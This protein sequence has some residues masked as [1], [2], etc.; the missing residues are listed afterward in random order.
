MSHISLTRFCCWMRVAHY[1]VKTCLVPLDS[2]QMGRYKELMD[3]FDAK[4]EFDVIV[5]YTQVG[6][7][8]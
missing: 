5:E 4:Y 1:T 3:T 2:V 7:A 8:C 6:T